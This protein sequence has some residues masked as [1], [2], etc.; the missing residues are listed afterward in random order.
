M[1]RRKFITNT[2]LA[3]AGLA[4]SSKVLADTFDAKINDFGF[5]SYT[6][7]DVIYKDMPGTLKKLKRAGYDYFEGFDFGN[8]KLLGKPVAEAKKIIEKSKLDL[9]SI[10]VLTGA[11]APD[12]KGSMMNEWQ[13]AIDQAA[14]L[15]ASYIV[16]AYLMDFERKS[17]DQYKE[18]A[19]LF[20]KCGEVAKKSGIQLCYHNHEFEFEE[21]DGQI[22]M[23]II[24]SET[25]SNNLKLELDIYWARYAGVDVIN[26]F[27]KNLKR[28]PLWHVKDLSL[29]KLPGTEEVK[30]MTEVG[31]GII[32]WRQVFVNRSN[33]GMQYFFVEQDRN[34]AEDSVSSLI[35]SIK[36]LKKLSV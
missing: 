18:L 23:D 24:L 12:L 1:D 17:I 4:A 9:K 21:L 26:F 22:P 32:D 29:K 35:T 5:Q 28:I 8:G 36:Y 34:F 13:M 3:T 10:H 15:G 33:S 2:A 27:T 6:V 19:E 11:A 30:P 14:E 7:R 31:N 25:D 16:C 20:N